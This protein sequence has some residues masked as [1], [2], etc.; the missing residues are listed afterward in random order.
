LTDQGDND[1][2]G[3]VG[4]RSPS[5]MVVNVSERVSQDALWARIRQ[6][7]LEKILAAYLRTEKVPGKLIDAWIETS[8]DPNKVEQSIEATQRLADWI[9][10]EWRA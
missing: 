1:H 4:R 5:G 9:D 10:G 3:E 6:R 8:S 2:P 7:N